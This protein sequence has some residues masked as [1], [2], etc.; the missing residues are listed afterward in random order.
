VQMIAEVVFLS[1]LHMTR[2]WCR[3]GSGVRIL[4]ACLPIRGLLAPHLTKKY[5]A[6]AG[7]AICM[8]TEE[9]DDA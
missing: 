5:L 7:N 3:N 8:R 1:F 4:P 6:L 9:E 2:T